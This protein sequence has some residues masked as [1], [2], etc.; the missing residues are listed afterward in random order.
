MAEMKKLIRNKATKHFLAEDGSWT[1]DPKAAREF[2]NRDTVVRIVHEQN[3]ANVEL[4]YLF[5]D[6]PSQYDFTL[7]LPQA[8]GAFLKRPL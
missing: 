2:Q 6:K 1:K 4:Y 3:L 7:S 8:N 5:E